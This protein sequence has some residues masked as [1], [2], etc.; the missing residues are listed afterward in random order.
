[1]KWVVYDTFTGDVNIF[2][3]EGEA[4]EDYEDAK[5]YIEDDADVSE[6]VYLLKV[7]DKWNP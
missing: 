3:T 6:T 1:M 7:K 2:D 5:R 4:K